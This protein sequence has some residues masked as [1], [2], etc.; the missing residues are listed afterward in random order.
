MEEASRQQRTSDPVAALATRVQH[1]EESLAFA[2][3]DSEE[4]VA[5]LLAVDARLR[6]L[7]RRVERLEKATEQRAS[8]MEDTERPGEV[9]DGP[10]QE[11]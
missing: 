8:E 2:Q 6:E 10:T 3:R 9:P 5:Q 7:I 1:L 11:P 4:T